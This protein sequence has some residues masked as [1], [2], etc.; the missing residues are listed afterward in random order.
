MP[1][2]R[3]AEVAD[4]GR[5]VTVVANHGSCDD[6]PA[7]AVLETDGSVVLSASVVGTKD[8]PCTSDLRAKNVTVEL[9]RPLADRILLDAFTGRP[10]PYGHS[11][12]PSPSWS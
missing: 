3:L 11:E 2:D 12:G 5:S 9:D 4:D 10:V 7:V 6:G 8:G 1:L